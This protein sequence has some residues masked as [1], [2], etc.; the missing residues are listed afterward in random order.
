MKVASTPSYATPLVLLLSPVYL[1]CMCYTLS[2]YFR[3]A[4]AKYIPCLRVLLCVPQREL[5]SLHSSFI[6]TRLSNVTNRASGV[7]GNLSQSS[8]GQSFIFSASDSGSVSVLPFYC[9]LS[10]QLF[11]PGAVGKHLHLK[12]V[13]IINLSSCTNLFETGCQCLEFCS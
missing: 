1:F 5:H 6:S 11:K 13:C 4:I 10:D 7:S 12:H 3:V 9:V 2:L 8:T